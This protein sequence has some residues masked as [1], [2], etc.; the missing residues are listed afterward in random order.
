MLAVMVIVVIWV[1]DGGVMGIV[2]TVVVLGNDVDVYVVLVGVVDVGVG[3]GVEIFIN[4]GSI[5]ILGGGLRVNR[6]L[7][8]YGGLFTKG[9][10]S[11]SPGYLDT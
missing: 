5:T 9:Y 3:V 11:S 10:L 4:G 7:L 6:L 1:C 2:E 8:G